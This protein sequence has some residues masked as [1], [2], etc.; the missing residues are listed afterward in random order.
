MKV[1]DLVDIDAMLEDG[2]AP[3]V[4]KHIMALASLDPN[5]VNP[6][7]AEELRARAAY[8]TDEG[9]AY[10]GLSGKKPSASAVQQDGGDD[11]SVKTVIELKD[12]C[13]E[14]GLPVSGSK[15]ALIERLSA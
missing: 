11:L 2:L 10:F 3:V 8:F 9:K 7:Q 12:M 6:T 13:A 14:R 5:A 15:A 1:Q 4:Q